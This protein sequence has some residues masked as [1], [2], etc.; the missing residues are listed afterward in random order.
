MASAKSLCVIV[1]LF[2]RALFSRF[3]C[4]ACVFVSVVVV[5]VSVVHLTWCGIV[6]LC[7]AQEGGPG[8][9]PCTRG[10]GAMTR[11]LP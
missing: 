9:L 8:V 1:F 6:F 3:V 10:F 11:S 2:S 4:C 5:V 7:V